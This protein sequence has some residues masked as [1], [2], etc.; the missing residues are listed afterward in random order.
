MIRQWYLA[1]L[2]LAL[3]HIRWIIPQ[4]EPDFDTNKITRCHGG[5]NNQRQGSPHRIPDTYSSEDWQ[6]THKRGTRQSPPINQWEC[7]VRVVKPQRMSAQTPCTDNY[8]Q[9]LCITDVICDCAT[10]KPGR[11]PTYH[12]KLPIPSNRNWNFPTKSS[13]VSKIHF[14]WRRFEKLNHHSNGTSLTVTTG[15]PANRIWK[16][17]LPKYATAFVR[18]MGR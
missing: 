4:E 15:G 18:A 16:S 11:L 17:F 8:K 2:H 7:G 3:Q 1:N 12:G 10:A 5:G 13:N 9:R 6:G 14:H